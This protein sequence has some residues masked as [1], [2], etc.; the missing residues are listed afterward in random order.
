METKSEWVQ[1]M[2]CALTFDDFDDAK[3]HIE[4][5]RIN[6]FVFRISGQDLFSVD[7]AFIAI[8]LVSYWER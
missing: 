6:L 1:A 4:S 5:L 3:K 7:T 2:G 8:D